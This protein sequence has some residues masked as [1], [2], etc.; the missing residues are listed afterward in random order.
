GSALA[1]VYN[2][3]I[4][5][6]AN[7]RDKYT[8]VLWGIRDFEHRFGRKPE[9]MWLPE[10][11]VDLESLSI[12]AELG[13][14]FT[15]LAPHQASRVRR[16]IGRGGW[17]D[18]S[19]SRIDPK[20]PYLVRLPDGREI[21]VF[22]YDG[23]VSQAVAFENLLVRGE[24]L[25]ERLFSV[26]TAEE[27]PQLVHIA[28]DGETYGHHHR[29]GDMALAYAIHHIESNGVARLTN[30]GQ[31]LEMFP[32]SQLVTIFENTSWSC[33]HGVERWRS[34]CGC[35]T[36]GQPD[37]NQEWR[38]PL[39]NSLDWLRD[40]V[41]PLYETMGRHY[42]K[43]P[44]A[45]RDDYIDVILDRDADSLERYF[46]KHA[47]HQLS[48]E[49]RTEALKLLE[50]QRHAMLMYTSCGWFFSELSG[51]ETVQV[52]QYAGRVIQL[53]QELFGGTQEEQFL[54]RLA[55]AK[56]NLPEIGDGRRIYEMF[57]R[58]ATIDLL[59]V[60]AHYAVSSIFNG[61]DQQAR[62]YCYDVE[63]EEYRFSEVGRTR[64]ALGRASITSVI[65]RES[66]DFSFAALHL[67]GHNVSAGLS[68]EMSD[69]AF[70]KLQSELEGASSRADLPELVRIIDRHFGQATYSLK[71]LF[72]GEQRKIMGIIMA[73]SLAETESMYRHVYENQAP[74]MR[75]L[76]D[77]STPIPKVFVAAAEFVL[78]ADLRDALRDEM[79]AP[80]RIRF[81]L[82]EARNWQV[83]LDA[84]GLSFS[85]KQ[86]LEDLA[87]ELRHEPLDLPLLRR[88]E[89]LAGLAV[90]LPF[91][92]DLWTPQNTY[93]GLLRSLYPQMCGQ[94]LEGD[95]IAQT[96]LEHFR[97]LG[98][99][100]SI[101]VE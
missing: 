53:A 81:I 33:G 40:S 39:R 56:S 18:V 5:P 1:Q 35:Q 6:L 76:R 10:T 98:E 46:G 101:L 32:P 31:F 97:S 11:A 45:A 37:W 42:L 83:E 43:D 73:S 25:V 100:L 66:R 79:P 62:V 28:T 67:G 87:R 84:E 91:E 20:Q 4:M 55:A 2:H 69:E 94:A 78:N 26:F 88:L 90:I 60:G 16:I 34:N 15:V 13:I 52:L 93:Y 65:T 36:G 71:S 8:Q 89:T 3:L 47:S 41:A 59:D 80:E 50:L 38:G 21:N 23:P 72:R 75:F 61:Y 96:W 7:R 14:K 29:H 12:M 9:G 68:E 57:V 51:I 74:L 86:T 30:Y 48:A 85:L 24:I 54:Q 95:E 70:A 49:E 44:W 63:R 58:P 92:V 77:L 19:G 64:L 17:R 27:E 22:F 82:N 99:K